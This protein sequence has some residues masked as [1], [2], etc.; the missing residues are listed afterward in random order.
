MTVSFGFNSKVIS[1][2]FSVSTPVGDSVIAKKVYRV[3]VVSIGTK[4][5]LVDLFELDMVNFDV[6]LGMDVAFL[7][8]ILDS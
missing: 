1:N 5:N 7:L 3:C 8:G 6:I 4:K 2:P